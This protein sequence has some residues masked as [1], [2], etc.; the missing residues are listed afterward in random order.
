M[1]DSGNK[2]N[3]ETGVEITEAK[4]GGSDPRNKRALDLHAL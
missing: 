4:G 1:H 2:E 3:L